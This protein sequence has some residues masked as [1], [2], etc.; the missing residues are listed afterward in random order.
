MKIFFLLI[1]LFLHLLSSRS[2]LMIYS[3]YKT[4]KYC[5]LK[6]VIVSLTFHYFDEQV[7]F[8]KLWHSD[9]CRLMWASKY[10]ERRSCRILN[11]V[12]FQD[13]ARPKSATLFTTH[14]LQ[15]LVYVW[16]R[17]YR[18]ISF[19]SVKFKT[20][21][22]ESKVQ[23]IFTYLKYDCE[24]SCPSKCLFVYSTYQISQV[25]IPLYMLVFVR[26][27]LYCLVKTLA[28]TASDPNWAFR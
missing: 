20:V 9:C 18:P 23:K 25:R 1:P 17:P 8:V 27:I 7:C 28:L 12:T 10:A 13:S 4:V 19:Q 14:C 16:F 11:A 6:I 5:R 24:S 26:L 2:K 21:I 22:Y 15:I 3:K